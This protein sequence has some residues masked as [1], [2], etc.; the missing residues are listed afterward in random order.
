MIENREIM[1]ANIKRLME[2][3]HV[4]ATDVCKALNFK[5]NTFSDW[6]NAK[7]YPRIDAIEMLAAYFH[8]S[9][10]E[11]VEDQSTEIKGVKR[12]EIV[13]SDVKMLIDEYQQLD[14]WGKSAVLETSHREFKRCKAQQIKGDSNELKTQVN[15]IKKQYKRY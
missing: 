1:A 15:E 11:L 3:N 6:V 5:Q 7:T 14:V 12:G 9:K 2:R 4:I 13:E 8:V 10:S